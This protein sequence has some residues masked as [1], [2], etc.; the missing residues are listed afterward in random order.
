M[1]VIGAGPAGLT[2]AYLL[3]QRGVNA[4]VLEADDQVGGISRT[5]KYKGFRFDIERH[6]FLTK[7]ESVQHIWE[8]LLGDELLT[9]PRLCRIH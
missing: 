3:A 9:V 2:A 1:V 8:E 6:R 7:I 4:T 5:A